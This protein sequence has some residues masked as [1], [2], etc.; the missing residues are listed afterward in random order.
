MAADRQRHIQNT[1]AP[2]DAGAFV[3]LWCS[4]PPDH[5]AGDP[6]A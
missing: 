1:K 4:I 2:V 5:A 3:F 6:G